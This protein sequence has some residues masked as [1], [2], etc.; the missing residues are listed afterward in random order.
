MSL[1]DWL[2]FL[3]VLAAA[4][5]VAA[6][7]AY[8][9]MVLGDRGGAARRALALPSTVLWTA[10]SLGVLVLGI[11]LAIEVDAYS[12]ADGWIIAAIVLWLAGSAAGG[13]LSR[14]MRDDGAAAHGPDPR[15]LFAVMAA[16]TLLLLADMIFKPGA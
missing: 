12:P 6:V 9:V 5:L 8:G 11:A 4:S 1:Y 15:V 2:L 7:T 10:G 13:N 3:H 14:R 16:T